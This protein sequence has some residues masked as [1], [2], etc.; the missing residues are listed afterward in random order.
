MAPRRGE[1][2]H[3]DVR[4]RNQDCK[5][6]TNSQVNATSAANARMSTANRISSNAS[7]R[8]GI[9]QRLQSLSPDLPKIG[10]MPMR[11]FATDSHCY[12]QTE[13]G[14][15]QEAL[16][17]AEA[18]VEADSLQRQLRNLRSPTVVLDDV[19]E[20]STGLAEKVARLRP[21]SRAPSGGRV[22]LRMVKSEGGRTP[23]E[24]PR[25]RKIRRALPRYISIR[26]VVTRSMV[27]AAEKPQAKSG[28]TKKSRKPRKNVIG[29][30]SPIR[31]ISNT[32][33]E[34]THI[35]IPNKSGSE[36]SEKSIEHDVEPIQIRRYLSSGE[37]QKLPSIASRIRRVPG[38]YVSKHAAAEKFATGPEG[39]LL[40]RKHGVNH[41]SQERASDLSHSTSAPDI[42]EFKSDSP[43]S[44]A[45]ELHSRYNFIPLHDSPPQKT[46]K[47]REQSFTFRK[48]K[49]DAKLPIFVKSSG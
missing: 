43:R 23:P 2:N 33:T 20:S 32:K 26:S 21:Q 6:A 25:I 13:S 34:D 7:F 35:E 3:F 37:A 16:F 46:P 24:R 28:E 15:S 4:S 38:L 40:V 10:A 29:P 31:F 44:Q 36:L 22:R 14:I 19:D 41:R 1:A 42:Q 18:D 48:H 9:T 5:K 47:S 8:N 27:A 11:L 17:E 39:N 12:S 45:R 30:I 49:S